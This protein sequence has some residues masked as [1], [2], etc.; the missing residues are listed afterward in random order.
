MVKKN[1]HLVEKELKICP[2]GV[3]PSELRFDLVSKDWIVIATGRARRPETFKKEERK[4]FISSKKTC[5][6]EH[7]NLRTQEKP[8]LIFVKGKKASLRKSIPENWTTVVIPNKFPAFA[9]C[10]SSNKKT[11][12]PY[13]RIDAMGFHEVVITKDHTR[14][15]A[16]FSV[17]QIKEVLD[18]YQDR[19]LDFMDEKFVHYISIFHNQ[20][21]TAGASISHPH[22]QII[23]MPLTDPDIQSSIRGAERFFHENKKCVH[24][25]MNKWDLQDGRRIVFKNKDFIAVCPFASRVAFEVRIFPREHHAYF[26]R[27]T[28]EQKWALAE[29][30]QQTLKRI[31]KGLN[32]PDYNFFLHTAPCD[33]MHYEHYH[34]HF[35]ILPKTGVW[36]GFE[37]GTGMEISTIEP[38]KAAE[39]LKKQ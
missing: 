28:N 1:S 18:V 20:G 16:Q 17:D 6:F 5:P 22:S 15:M 35:E 4:S 14:Q 31:Y 38:E 23:A 37:L 33:G 7:K 27:I 9:P 32:N 36:A 34:W 12:G 11:E 19:Y 24:C 39:Y 10:R 3:A 29:A 2:P 26:E 30:F 25:V 13:H 8:T 21:A